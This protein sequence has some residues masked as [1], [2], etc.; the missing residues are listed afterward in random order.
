MKRADKKA[1]STK[2]AGSTKKGGKFKG[3]SQE[4]DQSIN[5]TPSDPVPFDDEYLKTTVPDEAKKVQEM[6]TVFVQRKKKTKL[7]S[8][9]SSSPK[10]SLAM[11]DAAV[12]RKLSGNRLKRYTDMLCDDAI[13]PELMTIRADQASLTPEPWEFIRRQPRYDRLYH[14]NLDRSFRFEKNSLNYYRRMKK[15]EMKTE[16]YLMERTEKSRGELLIRRKQL[17]PKINPHTQ[18]QDVIE[19]ETAQ[20]QSE[21][22]DADVFA[23]DRYNAIH[24]HGTRPVMTGKDKGLAMTK[25]WVGCPTVT[26]FILSDIGVG[27]RSFLSMS[28]D[29]VFDPFQKGEGKSRAFVPSFSLLGV[30]GSKTKRSSRILKIDAKSL[31]NVSEKS[32]EGLSKTSMSSLRERISCRR[33]ITDTLSTR[34]SLLLG[35]RLLEWTRE[36][37]RAS[38]TLVIETGCSS[39]YGRKQVG[40]INMTNLGTTSIYFHWEKED[41]GSTISSSCHSRS[42]IVFDNWG[43]V[44]LPNEVY[45]VPFLYNAESLGIH[46]EDW[47]LMTRPVLENGAK[48]LLRLTGTTKHHNL[49][50]GHSSKIDPWLFK[51]QAKTIVSRIVEDLVRFLPLNELMLKDIQFPAVFKGPESF[52]LLNQGFHYSS[53]PVYRLGKLFAILE[54]RKAVRAE[55]FEEEAADYW[56]VRSKEHRY[57]RASS[58]ISEVEEEMSYDDEPSEEYE[59]GGEEEEIIHTAKAAKF[60]Y[61]EVSV[62][63]RRKTRAEFDPVKILYKRLDP[64]SARLK[65]YADDLEENP[66]TMPERDSLMLSRSKVSLGQTA[67]RRSLFPTAPVNMVFT[68]FKIDKLRDL[69]YEDGGN[70]E[71]QNAHF[72]VFAKEVDKICFGH[73][74]M[75]AFSDSLKLFNKFTVI[76]AT[77]YFERKEVI[78][79]RE[80]APDATVSGK[81]DSDIMRSPSMDKLELLL[82]TSS[83]KFL[84]SHASRAKSLIRVKDRTNSEDSRSGRGLRSRHPSRDRPYII[85]FRYTKRYMPMLYCTLY[86]LLSE[87]IDRLDTLFYSLTEVREKPQ[88]PETFIKVEDLSMPV[89]IE[90]LVDIKRP[91]I[92]WVSLVKKMN[93]ITNNW[94]GKRRFST[95]KISSA[96]VDG[97]NLSSAHVDGGKISSAQV[98]GVKISSAQVDGGKIS[99]AQVDGVNISS[100]QVD[101]GKISSAQVDGVNISSAKVDGVNISSAQVDGVNISSAQRDGVNISSAQV[102]GVNISRAQ[103]DGVNISSAQVDG[104]NISSAQVDGVKIS[105]A[106]VDGVNISSAQ[107]DGVNIS[108]AQV[109]GVKISSA[110]VDGVNISSAKVDGVKKSSAKVDDVNIS[111]AQV[112]DVNISSAQVDGV[113]ISSAQRD[114]VNI[115]SAQVDGVNI[116]RAQ[117]DGVNISSAQV[118]GVKISSAQVDGVNISSAQVDGVNISSAQVD[119]VKISSAQVDGVNISSAKVDGVKKSSAKVDDVNIS[120]AQVDDVN[121]SSAQV[122]GVNISSAKVD[123]VN[124]SSAQVDGVNISSAQRDGVNISSAQVDGVNISSAQVDGVNISSAQVDGVNISSAQV[125]GVKISIAQVDSVNISS[126]QLDGRNISSARV[127]GVKISSAQVDGVNLSSAQVDGVNISSAQAARHCVRKVKLRFKSPVAEPNMK[128]GF[129][130]FAALVGCALAQI[131]PQPYPQPYP[132]PNP[133]PYPQ[134]MPQP[135]PQPYPQPSAQPMP[136]PY[137]QPMPQP[138]PQPNPQ[139]NPQPYPQPSAQPMPQ[140][141]PQPKPQPYPQPSAQPNPQPYPQ[142]MPQPYPQPNPQPYPQPNAQPMPQPYPQPQPQPYPQ[143]DPK[144]PYPMPQNPPNNY[145]YPNGDMKNAPMNGQVYVPIPYTGPISGPYIGVF[146]PLFPEQNYN[147]YDDEDESTTT[148][149]PRIYL[150]KPTTTTPTTTKS[151]PV[152][153]PQPSNQYTEYQPAAQSTPQPEPKAPAQ[154]KPVFEYKPPSEYVPLTTSSPKPTTAAPEESKPKPVIVPAVYTQPSPAADCQLKE[155]Q[156]P[157]QFINGGYIMDCPD[158]LVFS[159]KECSCVFS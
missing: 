41:R 67:F 36:A 137:P 152:Y 145:P 115:S 84:T 147:P 57:S 155:A 153:Y 63:L 126:K 70:V 24:G 56:G 53:A 82:K 37:D 83:R 135:Y 94:K 88:R 130:L 60:S 104:V 75:E 81:S 107:V 154:Y 72:T 33:T 52:L 86:Q 18:E 142:P 139:P 9:G 13:C 99:S 58:V 157:S 116:S 78:I 143:P 97:V 71:I 119:G 55:G 85:D 44:I 47:R 25:E 128:N 42:K 136:Q 62:S 151:K 102:D 101:G 73:S 45:R 30:V 112:D 108:S 159:L 34:V 40:S 138:Y 123:G 28:D 114:G 49:L 32:R 27:T 39:E 146:P 105:S 125:D 106:Q 149:K 54:Q 96:Q 109:D 129:I 17:L 118:D 117:V 35:D 131:Y 140:P 15:L 6:R 10:H 76:G 87:Y 7:L 120:S 92:K 31:T 26:D 19:I 20:R 48:V 98:D 21:T 23:Y 22:Q 91:D 65:V 148:T 77:S 158:G 61:K 2:K 141:Y 89:Q 51:R 43:G 50:R 11:S 156:K 79:P 122:D 69:I 144:Q 103:V 127:D 121:I 132:P 111:S 100:A 66:M 93:E 46:S 12:R 64:D 110:Q 29:G 8:L 133:Q 124:I 68:D 80:T 150:T 4:R 5:F 16:N 113:N 90:T 95:V 134:P 38:K 1:P 3:T 14:Y 59:E 74:F